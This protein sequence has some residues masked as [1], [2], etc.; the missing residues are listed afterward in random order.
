MIVSY[1]QLQEDTAGETLQVLRAIANQTATYAILGG[2]LVN[3][4]AIASNDALP[5]QPS[6]AAI[7]INI[8]WFT[9]LV[10]SLSTASFAILV[11][12][13][14][15]SY[16][17]FASSSPQGQLRI[18][19]FRRGGLK[20]WKVFGIASMLPLFLQISLALFFV[21]LCIFTIDV[22]SAIGNTAIPLVCAW[23]FLFIAVTISPSF[24]ARCPYTT[25]ALERV[26]YILRTTITPPLSVI[27]FKYI[28]FVF[29]RALEEVFK[30]L[31]HISNNDAIF[32]WYFFYTRKAARLSRRMPPSLVEEV[33]VIKNAQQ[34]LEILAAADALQA[35]DRLL[36]TTIKSALEQSDANW[37]Q[38]IE[39][40]VRII[41]N[42]IPVFD[43]DMDLERMLE[44]Y[45]PL[46]STVKEVV[47]QIISLRV[48]PQASAEK[49]L[50]GPSFPEN[51]QTTVKWAVCIFTEVND[52]RAVAPLLSLSLEP[53]V[54]DA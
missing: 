53:D 46:P 29:Y 41:G 18:R 34:D 45:K 39:F 47:A 38:V 4:T 16:M 22:H 10:I 44:R 49:F 35:D 32:P 2:Q 28:P 19:H 17:A 48:I 52:H 5:F 7:R 6:L 42:R 30:H 8:L 54:Y 20:A 12:Q 50:G 1:P 14:L 13:W 21:G 36:G 31:Y 33:D 26:T 9:S 24:T 43:S 23:A 3:S 11:K 15:R 37:V 27:I 25:P 40:V 51:W